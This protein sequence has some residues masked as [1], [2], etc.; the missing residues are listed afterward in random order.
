MPS[1]A[2]RRAPEPRA[3]SAPVGGSRAAA[4][5][6]RSHRVVDGKRTRVVAAWAEGVGRASA[7]ADERM[8]S[9]AWA[10]TTGGQ[11]EAPDGRR[12]SVGQISLQ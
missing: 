3:Q 4:E 1:E 12:P 6:A 5:D 11:V 7:G 9:M 10:E 8:R 2:W